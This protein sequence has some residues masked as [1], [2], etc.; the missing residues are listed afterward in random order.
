[1]EMPAC[2]SYVRHPTVCAHGPLSI[3]E[4]KGLGALGTSR[5]GSECERSGGEGAQPFH[6]Y[7]LTQRGRHI[8]TLQLS[9]NTRSMSLFHP[10]IAAA[11]SVCKCLRPTQRFVSA[12]F[13]SLP[14]SMYQPCPVFQV[15]VESQLTWAQLPFYI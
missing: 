1:M 10:E 8:S 9:P 6:V 13:H 12:R 5:T 15:N 11:S 3:V 14:D 7:D 2:T 4:V